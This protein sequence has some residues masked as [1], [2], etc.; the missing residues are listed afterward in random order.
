MTTINH[1]SFDLRD[2]L[3]LWHLTPNARADRIETDGFVPKGESR[4]DHPSRAIW[5]SSSAYSFMRHATEID[6]AETHSGFLIALPISS[7]AQ[8]WDRQAADEFT[9]FDPVPAETILCRLP[10]SE[11]RDRQSLADALS[12]AAG[13]DVS[14][15]LSQLVLDQDAPWQQR[16][17]PASLLM[18]LDRARYDRENVTA[19]ALQDALPNLPYKEAV[20]VC[21]RLESIDLR[22]YHFFLRQYYFTYGER[23]AVRALLTAATRRIGLKRVF[24]ICAKGVDPGPNH[25]CRFLADVLPHI[26]SSDLVLG[27]WES[28]VMRPRQDKAAKAEVE[29]WVQQQEESVPHAWTHIEHGLKTFH[30]RFGEEAVDLS[31]SIVSEAPDAFDRIM[32][33]TRSRYPL[34]Q[35]GA[36]RA[37]GVVADERAVPYLER[38]LGE[39]W[40]RMRQEAVRALGSMDQDRARKL[41][42]RAI[43]DRAGRVRRTARSVLEKN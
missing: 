43:G 14:N 35:L 30:A 33:I 1:L 8:D 37:L 20:S 7:I 39:R 28:A 24:S 13:Q 36:V 18:Y 26:P 25:V 32:S 15:T 27:L 6:N 38:C 29:D 10:A 11:L 12:R 31:A 34:A 40:K 42:E 21:R 17:S 3:F 22:F 19:I 9:A 23:H 2:C 4:Q 5:F 16:T 41:V